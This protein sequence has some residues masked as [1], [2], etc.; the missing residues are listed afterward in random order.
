[1][2]SQPEQPIR[3]GKT[4]GAALATEAGLARLGDRFEEVAWTL[5]RLKVR[6]VILSCFLS[7]LLGALA[8]VAAFKLWPQPLADF[9]NTPRAIDARLLTLAQIDATLHVKEVK[10]VT[11][12]YFDG[13]PQP[14][15]RQTKDGLNY[16]YFQ[17]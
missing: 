7:S 6:N 3:P 15:S 9:F 12:V 10:G 11:Y 16:L 17:P 13:Q 1:M 2:N 5:L 14:N 8:V 4:N